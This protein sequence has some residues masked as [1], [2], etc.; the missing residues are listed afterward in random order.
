MA[1]KA[2]SDRREKT[3]KSEW[4]DVRKK[5]NEWMNE[6]VSENKEKQWHRIRRKNEN[7]D[8]KVENKWKTREDRK[9]NDRERE[10]TK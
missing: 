9:R 10:K 5:W 4:E 1:K 3:K 2:R 7:K 6:R 8:G